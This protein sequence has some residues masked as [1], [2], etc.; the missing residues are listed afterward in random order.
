[1]ARA[2]ACR[3]RGDAP[4]GEWPQIFIVKGEL[5]RVV[6]EAEDALLGSGREVY[7]R[8]GQLVR[9]LFLPTIPANDDWKFTP[10]T[11]PWLVEALTC[12]ARF[13]KYDARAKAFVPAD[14]PD[15][16]AD[17]LLSRGGK[18]KMPVLTGISRT[19]F[20]R[21]DGSVCDTPGYD[22]ASGVLFKP[23]SDSFPPIPL[24]SPFPTASKD[25]LDAIRGSQGVE[26]RLPA[27][28][29]GCS[30]LAKALSAKNGLD[31]AREPHGSRTEGGST[32]IEHGWRSG[33]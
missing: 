7:Q 31:V 23:G 9:P 14:A 22:P 19:P 28:V 6:D 25:D 27:R 30:R 29:N 1:M 33:A 32:V 15:E 26:D 4:A 5:P 17:A 21:R 11:R 24:A 20:L 16:V 8:S 3:R 13:L 2:K 18:W 12:A 10:L